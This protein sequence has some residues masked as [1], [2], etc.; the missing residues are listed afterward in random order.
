MRN[1]RI[2]IRCLEE[3]RE[4]FELARSASGDKSIAAYVLRRA[5]AGDD[6]GRLCDAVERLL[7]KLATT[8]A[9]TFGSVR[10]SGL[11]K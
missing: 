6:V 10:V 5:R 9:A 4:A 1:G 3:D 7:A 8:A 2:H 11:V